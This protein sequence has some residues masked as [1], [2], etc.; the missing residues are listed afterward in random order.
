VELLIDVPENIGNENIERIKK[1]MCSALPLSVPIKSD[2]EIGQRWS[3]RLDKDVV[4][5]LHNDEEEINY[6]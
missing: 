4:D 6:E 3:E 1:I 5:E 2:A